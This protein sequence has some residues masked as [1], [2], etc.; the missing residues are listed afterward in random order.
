MQGNALTNPEKGVS[1]TNLEVSSRLDHT[2]ETAEVLDAAFWNS[3]N[4]EGA[5]QEMHAASWPNLL[6]PE[7]EIRKEFA[8]RVKADLEESIEPDDDSRG[9]WLTPSRPLSSCPEEL[10]KAYREAGAPWPK[11]PQQLIEEGYD[12]ELAVAKKSDLKLPAWTRL[13]RQHCMKCKGC[14]KGVLHSGCYF[15]ELSVFL[16]RGFT[17]PFKEGFRTP[18]ERG[19]PLTAEFIKP[20]TQEDHALLKDRKKEDAMK[21]RVT[22]AVAGIPRE[23]CWVSSS[24]VA[25]KRLYQEYDFREPR[26]VTALNKALNP[27]VNVPSFSLITI[28]DII[29]DIKADE[30]VGALDLSSAFLQ[31]PMAMETW[32]FLGVQS[33]P[34]DPSWVELYRKLPFGLSIAPLIFSIFAAEVAAA[35]RGQ[36]L[37]VWSYFDDFPIIVKREHADKDFASMQQLFKEMGLFFK[38]S[39]TQPPTTKIKILGI[40]L[41]LDQGT[42]TIPSGY[43]RKL[44]LILHDAAKVDRGIGIASMRSLVGRLNYL[45]MVFPEG[46]LHMRGLY[47]AL[48]LSLEI[49]QR[50][51]QGNPSYWGSRTSQ[52]GKTFALLGKRAPALTKAD[53]SWWIDTL[54]VLLRW[55]ETDTSSKEEKGELVWPSPLVSKLYCA[56][57]TRV[58]NSD[59]SLDYSAAALFEGHVYLA[60]RDNFPEFF[61]NS[62]DAELLAA[63]LPILLH[64]SKF[65]S[66]CVV[67]LIDNAGACF[68]LNAFRSKREYVNRLLAEVA[69]VQKQYNCNV[70]A[71]WLPREKNKE[72][73]LW[74]RCLTLSVRDDEEIILGHQR[75]YVSR[76]KRV[77]LSHVFSQN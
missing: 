27:M 73:D 37:K 22:P 8:N 35:C 65:A 1:Q 39:K 3:L 75:F 58:V 29:Q 43:L 53:L 49:Q 18:E 10:W 41:D 57:P 55:E 64:P 33:N 47:K 42:F 34:D 52:G 15:S 9:P 72:A 54:R 32:C 68:T 14:P 25:R 62:C 30:I 46:R 67:C 13:H 51:Y 61:H 50:K 24:F 11:S 5:K 76:C 31:V 66:S 19:P 74:S 20:R 60:H 77:S 12:P 48:Y 45:A 63:T 26:V 23:A 40:E 38:P 36:G 71:K 2:A 59:A 56:H 17:I 28:G 69:K 70:V 7:F 44:E 4:A 16:E 21:A 6:R